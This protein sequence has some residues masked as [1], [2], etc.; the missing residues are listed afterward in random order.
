MTEQ[1][2]NRE[3]L[4]HQ[5]M[6][7]VAR[8]QEKQEYVERPRNHRVL[9]WVLLVLVVLGVAFYYCWISGLFH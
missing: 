2:M 8:Q 9:A 6:E 4:E 1:E 5:A 7:A 3:E